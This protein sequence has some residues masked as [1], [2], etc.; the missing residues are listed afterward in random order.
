MTAGSA[1]L[2]LNTGPGEPAWNMALDEALLASAMARALP[3]LRLYGWT[4]PATTFGYFQR[5]ADVAQATLL[6]PLVRRP[7]GGG[8]VPHDRD[9]TYSL[10][11]PPG[12]AWY[13]LR[14]IDSYRSVHAWVV[15]A[16]SRLG[17]TAELAPCCRQVTPG[18]CFQGWEKFDVLWSGRKIGGAAQRRNRQGLLI[19]GSVQPP[20]RLDRGAWNAALP[21]AAP[22]AFFHLTEPLG[23]DT[24]TRQLAADLVE[25]KYSLETYNAGR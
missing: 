21:N 23:L 13:E 18:Q 8:M 12:H 10:A 19:Q 24:P 14:A 20:P 11:V 7:T 16:L 17:V 3:V 25:T 1:L 22:S 6:R 2:V 4:Q 5:H 15:V 9:W